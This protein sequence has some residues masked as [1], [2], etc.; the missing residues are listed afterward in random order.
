MQEIDVALKNIAAK[1]EKNVPNSKVRSSV[2]RG[3][4]SAVKLVVSARDAQIKIE[5]TPVL[6]GTVFPQ[7]I[8]AVSDRVQSEFGFAEIALVSFEDLYAGKLVAALDRQHPRDL[9]G[10]QSLGL[11]QAKPSFAL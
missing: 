1:I 3:T 11:F 7:Q 5:V 2:L 9:Y 6:R 10:C 4:D 8:R